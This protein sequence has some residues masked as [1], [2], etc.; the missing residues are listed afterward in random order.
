MASPSSTE[1]SEREPAPYCWAVFHDGDVH[2][3][4]ALVRNGEVWH[5][6]GEFLVG[7]F[8]ERTIRGLARRGI[9][10]KKIGPRTLRHDLWVVSDYEIDRLGGN[11]TPGGREILRTKTGRLLAMPRNT[12]PRPASNVHPHYVNVGATKISREAWTPGA[13]STWAGTSAARSEFGSSSYDA[14]IQALV[15]QLDQNNL[16]AKV[17]ELVVF[18][19]RRANKSG[20][21]DARD[22]IRGWF[23]GIGLSTRL[24]WISSSYAENVIAEIPGTTY[25]NEI[26]IVGGHYDSI[27]RNGQNLKAPGADDNASGT[28]GVFEVARILATGGP[29]ERTLRFIAFGAEEVGLYGSKKH[30][31]NAIAAGE[32]IVAMINTDMNAYLGPGDT[33][34]CDYILNNA[35]G[36]LSRFSAAVSGLYISNWASKDSNLMGG[37]SDHAPF[38]AAGFPAIFL[39]EDTG[40]SP[41]IHTV[42]DTLALSA[43]DWDLAEMIVKGVLVTAVARAEIV[44]MAITHAP[45]ED[46]MTSQGP[47]LVT[48]QVDSQNGAT[49][50]GAELV[51]TGDDGITY[52]SVTMDHVGNGTYEGYIP[53]LGSPLT[54]DYYIVST[55]DQ[56]STEVAPE[57]FEAGGAAFRFF[58][59]SRDEIYANGFEDP[60][61]D[62]WTR[63]GFPPDPDSRWNRGQPKGKAGD[64]SYPFDGAAV[65]GT[66]IGEISNDGYYGPNTNVYLRSPVIDCSGAQDNVHLQFRRWLTVEDSAHDQAQ[67]FVNN[68]PVW[69]NPATEDLVDTSWVPIDVDISAVAAGRP[70]VQIE[71]WL[72]SD[73]L[74]EYGGWNIDALSLCELQVA[75]GDILTYGSGVN[76]EGSMHILAGSSAIGDTLVLGL[77]NP[78]GTQGAGTLTFL[79]LSQAP[80]PGYPAGTLVDGLGMSGAGAPGELLIS[81][82]PPDPTLFL[83]GPVWTGAGIPAEVPVDIPNDPGLIGATVYGQGLLLDTVAAQGV[84]YGLTEGVVIQITP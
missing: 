20:C 9:E 31:N 15:D 83:S 42:N 24:E 2:L 67:I 6:S 80:D 64:A 77:D 35:N 65:W 60:D 12:K 66:D 59:G 10:S 27:N 45:L 49:V 25:P 78:L 19:N 55:D 44:D 22:L 7:A 28:S 8:S 30:A 34:D 57:G 73:D 16:L 53:C 40:Y 79:Y 52:S 17:Q 48:A 72:R 14:R 36:P 13:P 11:L 23:Q 58:V 32:N 47:F 74:I 56:G 4:D 41:Y 46:S 3:R 62:G 1:V 69:E 63:S 81:I 26:V 29:Y 38:T 50:T 43:I 33:R 75:T 39:F 61:H 54:V 37:S 68:T 5:D 82:V 71:F 21:W 84:R 76:P 51:F 70:S 18:Y